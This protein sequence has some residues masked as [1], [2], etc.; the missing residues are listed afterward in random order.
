VEELEELFAYH[1]DLCALIICTWVL[2]ALSDAAKGRALEA[3][4]SEGVRVVDLVK[5]G[6]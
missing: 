1:Q 3:T 2:K 6:N 4:E 5:A